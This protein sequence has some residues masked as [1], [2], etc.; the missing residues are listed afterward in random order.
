MFKHKRHIKNDVHAGCSG[1][2]VRMGRLC[3]RGC[4]RG[5]I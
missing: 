1:S 4:Y 5:F 3:R 2:R